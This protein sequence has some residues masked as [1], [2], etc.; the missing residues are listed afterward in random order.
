MLNLNL[1]DVHEQDTTLSYFD[2]IVLIINRPLCNLVIL[3]SEI[4]K[5]VL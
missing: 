3:G 1:Q 5:L 2:D 4:G